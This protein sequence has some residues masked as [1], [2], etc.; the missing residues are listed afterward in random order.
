VT[1]QRDFPTFGRAAALLILSVIGVNQLVAPLLL[2]MSLTR[3]REVGRRTA[4]ILARP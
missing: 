2:R 1:I 3:S 4:P